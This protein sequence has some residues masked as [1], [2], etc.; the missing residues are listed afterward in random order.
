MLSKIS[1]CVYLFRGIS[2]L[3]KE[4]WLLITEEKKYMETSFEMLCK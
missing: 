4:H 3:G 2:A 1:L